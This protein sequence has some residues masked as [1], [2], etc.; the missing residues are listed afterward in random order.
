MTSTQYQPKAGFSRDEHCAW[1]SRRTTGDGKKTWSGSVCHGLPGDDD[2]GARLVHDKCVEGR[3]DCWAWDGE[4]PYKCWLGAVCWLLT[5]RQ[6][7]VRTGFIS[8]AAFLARDCSLIP[9]FYSHIG[10]A[11][12][13]CTATTY[14][15]S[16]QTTP[17]LMA[18]RSMSGI[19]VHK[20]SLELSAFTM[21][22]GFTL[23]HAIDTVQIVRARFRHYSATS[24]S[25][26]ASTIYGHTGRSRHFWSF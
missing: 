14:S 11:P 8:G 5:C 12:I 6:A 2:F 16:T 26:A 21:R 13:S 22:P 23:T 1:R 10:R 17:K 9:R 3:A 20:K 25:A 24:P 15:T 19:L 7:Y 4:I 18:S